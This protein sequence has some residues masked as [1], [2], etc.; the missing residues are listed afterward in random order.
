MPNDP[1]TDIPGA[2]P[3]DA[4]KRVMLLLIGKP[5]AGKSTAATTFPNPL[6]LD[7]DHKVPSL[8][9]IE[10]Y[11]TRPPNHKAVE[12]WRDEFSRSIAGPQ[13]KR[14][15]ANV[16]DAVLIWLKTNL[17]KIPPSVTIVIDGGTSLERVFHFQTEKVDPVPVGK[18]GKPDSFHVWKEKVNYYG[19]LFTLLKT[20][21]GHVIFTMHEQPDYDEQGKT[22]RTIKPVMT[23]Q[24]SDTIGGHFTAMFRQIV[25]PD[26]NSKPK[27]LW[28]CK[29]DVAYPFNNTFGLAEQKVPAHY[30]S[31][32]KFF[33]AASNG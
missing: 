23:G 29:P 25:E 8:K 22:L 24:L 27:Y 21:P 13:D 18:T 19:A 4:D 15:P 2:S 20:H 31:I 33:Q 9:P 1:F 5:F 26:A 32:S 11:H 7:L 17:P 30:D 16:R 14:Y 28:V 6:F 12:F 3:P 10:G